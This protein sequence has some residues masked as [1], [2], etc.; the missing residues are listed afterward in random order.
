MGSSCN[1]SIDGFSFWGTKSYVD[2]ATLS[3]FHERDRQKRRMRRPQYGGRKLEKTI[4][5]AVDAQAM[6]ER[7]DAMGYT[8]AHARADYARGLSEEYELYLGAGF[9]KTDRKRVKDWTYDRW[10]AAVARLVPQGFQVWSADKFPGDPDA[11]RIS[12]GLRSGLGSYFS[13][14]RYMLRGLLDALP[15]AQE[16]ILDVTDLI[17]AGYYEG[18]EAICD[19]ARRGWAHEHSLYGSILLLTEGKTD[20]RILRAAF[21]A[22][23]PHLASL[24]GFLDF[25]GLR[26]EGSADMLPKTIRSFV[27]GG[28][29]QRVIAIF[30]NDTAGIAAMGTL[31][32]IRLPDHVRVMTLPENQFAKAYPTLGPQGVSMMDINGMACGIEMYLGAEAL[33]NSEGKL[34]PVRWTGYHQKLGRYQGAVEDKDGI[35]RRFLERLGECAGSAEARECFPVL[36]TVVDAIGAQFAGT[37]PRMKSPRENLSDG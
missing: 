18:A 12:D 35:A 15:G 30:D 9:S 36:A 4:I 27:G 8:V 22:I 3:V 10:C 21:E 16:A 24:Y 33:S 26:I 17:D 1:V 29:S 34:R 13:D 14:P 37:E 23:S 32:N 11:E 20:T 7:L 6:R 19:E 25:E 31:S 28:I 2:D 5:Y